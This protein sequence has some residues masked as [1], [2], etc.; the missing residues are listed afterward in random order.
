MHANWE[1][2]STILD[3]ADVKV[4]VCKIVIQVGSCRNTSAAFCRF[5]ALCM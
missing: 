1:N 2:I 3:G 4:Q 5:K